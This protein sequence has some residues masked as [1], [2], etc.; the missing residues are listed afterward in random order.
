ML[1]STAQMPKEIGRVAVSKAYDHLAGK[2]VEKKVLVPVKLVTKA[3]AD[4]FLQ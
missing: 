2:R 1:A 3:N 4:Q